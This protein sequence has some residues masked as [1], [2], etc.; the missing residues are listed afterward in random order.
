MKGVPH[1]GR[2]PADF[3]EIRA[4]RLRDEIGTIHRQ[5]D[6]PVALVYPSP[7][8]VG[9]SS[10]GYQTVYRQLNEL[11]G[12]AAERA[13]L[14]DDVAEARRRREPLA[15]YESGRPVGDFPVVAFSSP[16]SWSWPGWWTAWI[17][18]AF[19]R[20]RRIGPRRRTAIPWWWWEGRS[21]SPT[22]CRP[23]PTPT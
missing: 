9:M 14:P 19:P 15:T 7:Y 20:W 18:R 11:P 13:F 1:P 5:A 16:T 17:W 8:H 22:P 4:Q 23:G 12:C 10:L 6:L 3:R 2:R 21:P